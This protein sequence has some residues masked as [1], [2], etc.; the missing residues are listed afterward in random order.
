MKDSGENI[1][2]KK[3]TEKHDQTAEA[4]Q[5]TSRILRQGLSSRSIAIILVAVLAA[6]AGCNTSGNAAESK[7][8]TLDTKKGKAIK[9]NKLT[10]EEERVI[11]N[12][13]T[14]APFT[15][16]YYQLKDNGVYHCKRCD[17]PLYQSTDKF[18]SG[19]G[20]PSFDDKI[21]GA[22]KEIPDADGRRTEIVCAKCDAH[23][24]HVFRGER[25]TDKN[26]R[27]CV[28]SISLNF[29]SADDETLMQQVAKKEA[30]TETVTKSESK[31]EH[32]T[33]KAYFAGGCFWGTEY[34]LEKAEGVIK[35]R[36]GYMGG[37]VD[38]P[39]YE[40]V[41][42]GTTGH[43][44]AV[45]VEYDPSKTDFEALARLF[46]EI[47]DP[48]QVNRQGP[49]IGPQYRS[50]VFFANEEQ[51]KTTEK[52]IGLLRDKGHTVA[53]EVV[54][55]D[56]FWPAENYH[57]DYYDHNGKKPYCHAYEEKF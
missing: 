46:F 5:K 6:L 26:T 39:S 42:S 18:D 43:A 4:R 2:Q 57:Q 24:G 53:T 44:E 7:N 21:E 23:L 27:H 1:M 19:C 28:N 37:H 49:D 36:V 11:V 8:T 17:A 50:V 15:G 31:A 20:W 32:K 40:Q 48:D 25:L 47:H 10:P 33:S 9:M 51:K 30:A 56:K 35:A 16:K 55:A 22:V 29:A 54:K 12:K 52:L 3:P 34:F 38:N 13:G 14:E 41:C 45:E